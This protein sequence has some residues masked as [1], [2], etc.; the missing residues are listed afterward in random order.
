[1]PKKITLKERMLQILLGIPP[2]REEEEMEETNTG[3]LT[4]TD[5]V[6][7]EELKAH[8]EGEAEYVQ[9][10]KEGHSSGRPE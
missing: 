5:E 1:M 10:K 3:R 6:D 9:G 2:A 7:E 8:L 4:V